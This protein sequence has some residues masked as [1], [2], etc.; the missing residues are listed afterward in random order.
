M[1]KNLLACLGLVASITAS[2]SFHEKTKQEEEYIQQSKSLFSKMDLAWSNNL[3][4][5][6]PL[7]F[8]LFEAEQ[9]S[10]VAV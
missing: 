5:L 10:V 7:G 9:Q 1:R 8:V 2:C 6:A 4:L 3:A